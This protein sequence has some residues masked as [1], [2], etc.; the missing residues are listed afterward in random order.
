[1]GENVTDWIDDEDTESDDDTADSEEE[2]QQ[3]KDEEVAWDSEQKSPNCWTLKIVYK[4]FF[5]FNGKI[6][7]VINVSDSV[8]ISGQQILQLTRT[9]QARASEHG[10]GPLE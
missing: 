8:I 4:M 5:H 1:M 9:P 3:V 6:E 2:W 7:K 10:T